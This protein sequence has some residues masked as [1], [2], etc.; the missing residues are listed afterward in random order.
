VKPAVPPARSRR[1]SPC[2]HCA[3]PVG[4][5]IAFCL[6]CGLPVAAK[7]SQSA[8]RAA[9]PDCGTLANSVAAHFCGDCGHTLAQ[10]SSVAIPTD[11]RGVPAL[12]G[13]ARLTLLDSAGDITKVIPLDHSPTVVGRLAGELDAGS[14]VMEQMELS[15]AS[16]RIWVRPLGTASPIYLFISETHTLVDGDVL[17]IGSQLLRFRLLPLP[18]SREPATPGGRGSLVPGGD[19]AVVEQL[20]EDGSVRDRHHLAEGRSLLL[21]REHGEWVF[22]YDATMSARH[23]EI[24]PH[25][26]GG[27]VVRDLSSRNGVAV[28]MRGALDVVSG[29]RLLLGS[30]MMRVELA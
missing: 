19:V 12:P 30:Q 11:P 6:H 27:F 1:S 8:E 21:G 5:D 23:A 22:P 25:D 18:F 17:L 15:P 14:E 13:R 2:P 28:A 10:P 16:D 20:M 29:S 7:A 3:R 24:R 9:C 26:D 4:R